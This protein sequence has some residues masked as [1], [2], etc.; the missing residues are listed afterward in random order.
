[1]FTD[2]PAY[3]NQLSAIMKVALDAPG[4]SRDRAELIQAVLWLQTPLHAS[5]VKPALFTAVASTAI[6]Q[7][8]VDVPYV[9]DP[10]NR[11][12]GFTRTNIGTWNMSVKTA[13]LLLAVLHAS[14]GQVA[15]TLGVYNNSTNALCWGFLV[16]NYKFDGTDKRVR[17]PKSFEARTGCCGF[18]MAQDI[19]P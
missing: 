3:P 8:A 12:Y 13:H 17:C 18:F 15:K 9:A 14:E 7:P 5:R 1:M 16:K 19:V 6:L 11:H 2:T 10:L 4:W